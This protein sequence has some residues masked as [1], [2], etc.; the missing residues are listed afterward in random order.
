MTKHV[1]IQTYVPTHVSE[2]VK[3]EAHALDLS[4]SVLV[5]DIIM[6]AYLGRENDPDDSENAAKSARE[7]AFISVALDALLAGHPDPDLRQKA[8]DAYARKIER[9]GLIS[10]PRAGG[11]R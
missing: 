6:A 2:W 4:V 3:S 7:T 10:K 11:S 5:R 8:H 1:S 9:L